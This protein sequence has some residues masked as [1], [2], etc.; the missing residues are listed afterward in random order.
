[1]YGVVLLNTV[2][3]GS[4]KFRCD[5]HVLDHIPTG[6]IHAGGIHMNCASFLF[7]TRGDLAEFTWFVRWDDFDFLHKPIVYGV[8]HLPYSV[9]L[10]D[11]VTMVA[12]PAGYVVYKGIMLSR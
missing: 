1:M 10:S 4:P 6:G 9:A 3:W 12:S 7:K 8:A 5:S 2:Q 11:S